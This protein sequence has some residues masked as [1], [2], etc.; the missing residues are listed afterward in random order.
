MTACPACDAEI[1]ALA[2]LEGPR[3]CPQCGSESNRP[4]CLDCRVERKRQCPQ[5][6][7]DVATLFD[8]AHSDPIEPAGATEPVD[9]MAALTDGG[10]PDGDD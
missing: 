1:D 8:I 3:V 2:V 10:V 9:M 7:T 6:G 4:T 5:C